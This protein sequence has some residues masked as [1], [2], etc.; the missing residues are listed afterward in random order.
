[1][2]S[3]EIVIAPRP[4]P[5]GSAAA[6]LSDEPFAIRMAARLGD[7]KRSVD[8]FVHEVRYRPPRAR[9]ARMLVL[10]PAHNE[11]ATIAKTLD[12][13]LTQS[14]VPDRIVVIADNCTDDTE[15]IARRYRG[16]TVMRTVDNHDRKVGA[17]NQAWRRWQAGYDFIAGIDAD[18]QLAPDCL[19]HLEEELA[20]TPRAGGVM[21]RYTFD[22]RL[23]TTPMARLLIRLQRMEFAG[24]TMDALQK[25]RTTYVLGGQASLFNAD[26][27]RRVTERNN[28]PGP[29]DASA[30][31]EDMQ[32]TGD[33][34]GM[35]YETLVSPNAR[36]HAGAMLTFRSLWAQR[37][38][39]DEGMARLLAKPQLSKW[40]ATL[41]RQQLSLLSN[42]VT[43]LLFLF[44]L[45]FSL[46]VHQFV[47][48]WWWLTPTV[49]AS[50][51][52]AR[53]AWT[54]PNRT[55]GD[56]VTAMLLLP[57]EAYLWFRLACTT[58]SWSNVL[59][60]IKRDGWE[61]QAR[62]ERGAS[63]G[64][65]RIITAVAIVAVLAG[66]TVFGWLHAPLWLQERVLTVGWSL[67][68]VVT[69]LQ[70]LMMMIRLVRPSRGYRP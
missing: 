50:L 39:W 64:P 52:N 56:V 13:L 12:A 37:R 58:A 47:W 27:L 31:V 59:A 9:T 53:V 49:V 61:D 1:M 6:D 28:T 51:L 21:A 18:T 10:I 65:G 40:T 55:M 41:W 66:L 43:R 29:W 24:W 8:R 38:K 36:A 23:G 67:L 46:M 68:A 7:A 11:E 44:L 33:L 20:N 15:K 34:R 42:G 69:V 14:R 16:V 60:G 62:A 4:V 22:Q 35:R 30:Q 54:M 70:T 19:Q 17:L 25:N 26:A 32:L 45:T 5:Y 48:S 57:V 2:T 63:N 3:K